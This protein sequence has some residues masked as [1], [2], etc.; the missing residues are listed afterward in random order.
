MLM[1]TCKSWPLMS[2]GYLGISSFKDSNIDWDIAYIEQ[3]RHLITEK[4]VLANYYDRLV[5][6]HNS[7][8]LVFNWACI[9]LLSYNINH[10]HGVFV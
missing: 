1:K 8:L 9:N 6:W 4:I 3:R 5:L 10:E 7:H 2:N